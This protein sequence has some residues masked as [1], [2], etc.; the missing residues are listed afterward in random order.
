MPCK[1]TILLHPDRLTSQADREAL[2]DFME[3]H[4]LTRVEVRTDP[5]VRSQAV[6]TPSMKLSA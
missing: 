2:H 4:G 3:A 1:L 5:T 6:P